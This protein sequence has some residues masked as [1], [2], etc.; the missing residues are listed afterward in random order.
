[1]RRN[2]PRGCAGTCDLRERKATPSGVFA[3]PQKRAGRGLG[4]PR[5]AIG[6]S[7]KDIANHCWPTLPRNED[8]VRYRNKILIGTFLENR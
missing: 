5:P 1:M 2:F 4:C 6:I 3:S 8:S 7:E